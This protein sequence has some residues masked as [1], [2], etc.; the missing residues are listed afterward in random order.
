[1]AEREF[2]AFDASGKEVDWIDPYDWH[3]EIHSD[4][5]A[6]S[7]HHDVYSVRIPPGGHYEIRDMG[8]D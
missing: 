8:D 5:Y 6:V 1:M 3:K 2:V 4:Y 7:N